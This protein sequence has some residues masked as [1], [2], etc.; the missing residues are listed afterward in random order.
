MQ[1][2]HPPHT[3][4]D[5]LSEM[6]FEFFGTGRHSIMGDQ[7]LAQPDP[8]LLDVRSQEEVQTLPVRFSGDLTVLHI[9]TNEIPNRLAEIP[10]DRPLAVFCSAGIRAA[11]VYAYLKTMDLQQVRILVG[12][13][14]DLAKQA[15][16]GKI[17]MRRQARG[18][19]S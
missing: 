14:P 6:T 18:D 8:I 16:P 13:L 10:T 4:G 12:G 2:S 3:L 7:L 19:S 5:V 15:T 1:Q 17:W 9:P 11:M